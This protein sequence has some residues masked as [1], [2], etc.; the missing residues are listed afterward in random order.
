MALSARLT[1]AGT[2]ADG[3]DTFVRVTLAKTREGPRITEAAVDVEVRGAAADEAA[4][5]T[6]AEDAFAGC[7]VAVA[8]AAL[9]ARLGTV[10]AAGRTGSGPHGG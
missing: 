1:R 3:V 2:P 9:P 4:L 7:P 10:R 8:L 6:L 5:R